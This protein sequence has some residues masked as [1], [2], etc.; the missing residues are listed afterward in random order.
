MF[1]EACENRLE[2]EE[3]CLANS[4]KIVG[5]PYELSGQNDVERSFR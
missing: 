4:K 1:G 5:I 2:W 3:D